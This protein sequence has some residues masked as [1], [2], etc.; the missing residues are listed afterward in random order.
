MAIHWESHGLHCVFLKPT[1]DESEVNEATTKEKLCWLGSSIH[2]DANK[3]ENI[4]DTAAA[5]FF[6]NIYA[7][8]LMQ[9]LI[10][11][12]VVLWYGL[13]VA[14]AVYGCM[15][16]KEGL[17][18]INLLVEDSYAVPHYKVLEKYFWHYGA[19]VQVSSSVE[20]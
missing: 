2:P 11:F 5:L 1:I 6:Q 15:Q 8:V 7:P 3:K 4:R 19:A 17:E 14:F 10:R 9:P 12:L 13:Y 18:P 16:L 20:L